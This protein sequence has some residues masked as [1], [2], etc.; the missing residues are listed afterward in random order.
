MRSILSLAPRADEDSATALDAYRATLRRDER[1]PVCPVR[2]AMWDY[3][4]IV[5]AVVCTL[6]SITVQYA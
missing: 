6:I 4:L 5:L 2:S 1:C 3:G